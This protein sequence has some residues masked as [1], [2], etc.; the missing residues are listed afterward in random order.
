MAY[1]AAGK[2]DASAA[3][4]VPLWMKG[5]EPFSITVMNPA[6]DTTTFSIEFFRSDG[7]RIDECG[8]VCGPVAV[9][10]NAVH[11]WRTSD[12][13]AI[14][15]YESGWARIIADHH[16]VARV[17]RSGFPDHIADGSAYTA[18]ACAGASSVEGVLLPIGPRIPCPDSTLCPS[19]TRRPTIA[20]PPSATATLR[21][22]P[23]EPA[24]PTL[25]SPTASPTDTGT[26]EP[27]S[28]TPGLPTATP[29]VSTTSTSTTTPTVTRTPSPEPT[30]P[31]ALVCEFILNRV[32][33]VAIDCAIANPEMV[34]GWDE[35][36][37]PNLPPSPVNIRRH[38]L[39]IR[40]VAMPFDAW[41]NPLVYKAGCP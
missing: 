13:D 3:L 23:T 5:L 8:P 38:R 32:P 14:E 28:A 41:F 2:A 9:P 26:P 15:L 40:N 33:R 19:P 20:A 27:P 7:S 25:P 22:E 39:S 17:R 31:Y 4:L 6:L 36:A 30:S 29:T 12:I 37:F 10:S 34:Y 11:T 16:V 21:H 35:P 24:T 1:R 18:M